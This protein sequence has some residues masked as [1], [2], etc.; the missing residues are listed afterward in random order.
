M[1]VG[2]SFITLYVRNPLEHRAFMAEKKLSS[3]TVPHATLLS[4]IAYIMR[5]AVSSFPSMPPKSFRSRCGRGEDTLLTLLKILVE[6][7]SF[8]GPS[9]NEK[10]LW[11][12]GCVHTIDGLTTLSLMLCSHPIIEEVFLMHD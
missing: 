12:L 1:F 8:Y 2:Y 10:M 4:P 9:Q 11:S 7:L 5:N 6:Y 3:T